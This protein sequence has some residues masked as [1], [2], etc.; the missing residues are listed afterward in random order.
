MVGNLIGA[1]T[2][3]VV[4]KVSGRIES[5]QRAP[6]RPGPPGPVAGDARG[7]RAAGAGAPDRGLARGVEGHGPAARSRPQERPEQPRALPEPV[8]AQPGRAAD[9]RRRRGEVRRGA[10]PGRPGQGPGL[11]GDGPAGGAAHQSL[12]HADPLP[13]RRVRRQPA[14]GP[15]RVRGHQLVVPVGGGHPLRAPRGQP[16]REGSAADR[17]R[18]AGAV[19]EVDAYPGEMFG[20]RRPPRARARP[21]DAHGADGSRSPQPGL[22]A[23][24]RDVRARAVRRRS[25]APT[26]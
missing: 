8:R 15:R 5:R 24:A 11:P 13:G 26:P 19:V 2:V 3:D 21:G 7:P 4:P 1:A 12:E 6:G 9:A 16:G 23:E 22:A 25:S 18:H 17:H 20:T 10:G 14:P